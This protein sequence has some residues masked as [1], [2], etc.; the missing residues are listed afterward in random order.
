MGERNMGKKF[1]KILAVAACLALGV[2]VLTGCS[3][4]SGS[5][6]TSGS[7]VTAAECSTM[8]L[9]HIQAHR[10]TAVLIPIYAMPD[11]V[12]YVMAWVNVL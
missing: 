5:Q 7:S 11:G 8:V 2:S 9:P 4:G 10:Q 6:T 3:G 12:Q 1:T